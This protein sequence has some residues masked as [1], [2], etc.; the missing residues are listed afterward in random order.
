[1]NRKPKLGERLVAEIIRR[2]LEPEIVNVEVVRVGSKHFDVARIDSIGHTLTTNLIKDWSTRAGDS[3]ININEPVRIY[4]TR[5]QIAAKNE[6]QLRAAAV[7]NK[8]RYGTDWLTVDPD[9]LKTIT[10]IL[11]L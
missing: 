4:E 3:R 5:D 8:Y 11:G 2:H 10:E 6:H 1:M 7:A 9:K